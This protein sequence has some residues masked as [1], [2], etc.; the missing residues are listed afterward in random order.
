M[1]DG[2]VVI[3]VM[4]RR[5]GWGLTEGAIWGTWGGGGV[6]ERGGGWWGVAG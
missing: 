6:G 5:E 2:V 3:T 4:R 1:R